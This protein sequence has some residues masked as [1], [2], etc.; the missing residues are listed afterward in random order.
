M[1]SNSQKAEAGGAT[2]GEGLIV[3]QS[4]MRA[5]LTRLTNALPFIKKC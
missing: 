1:G 4:T 2:V 5:N 3:R